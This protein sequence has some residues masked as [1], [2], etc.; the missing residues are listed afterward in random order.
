MPFTSKT[1]PHARN[2]ARIAELE[3][4]IRELRLRETL[5]QFAG[6][7]CESVGMLLAHM[8]YEQWPSM[9]K[10]AFEHERQKA[11]TAAQLYKDRLPKG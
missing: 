6:S 7:L 1:N 3:E 10:R 5:R 9:A 8:P 4:E 2:R 11:P